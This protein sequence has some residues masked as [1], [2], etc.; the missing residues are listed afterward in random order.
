MTDSLQKTLKQNVPFVNLDMRTIVAT[1][2][3]AAVLQELMQPFFKQFGITHQ[4]FNVLRILRGAGEEGL[5]SLEIPKR[6]VQ[7][8]P[9][10]TRILRRLESAGMLIR[11]RCTEDRRVVFVQITKRALDLL[12]SMDEPLLEIGREI[13][14]VFTLEEQETFNGLLDLFSD[15]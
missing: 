13:C 9:D 6:M 11:R 8:V 12:A 2:R 14:S 4:Q 10:T 3:A 5:P 7:R 15:R 1:L